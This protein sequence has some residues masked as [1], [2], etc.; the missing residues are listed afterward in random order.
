M[1]FKLIVIKEGYKKIFIN[2]P[3]AGAETKIFI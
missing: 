3:I 2:P 1:G